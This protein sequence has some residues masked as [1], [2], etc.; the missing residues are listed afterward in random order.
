MITD[1]II[2]LRAPEPSDV[3]TLYIWENDRTLWPD[4]RTRAPL[5]RHQLW[6][7]IDSYSADPLAEGQARFLIV[8]DKSGESVGAVDLFDID[9]VN[10][11]AAV[12][13]F[14]APQHRCWGI[15]LR[16][17]KLIAGYCRMELGL[18]QLWAVTAASNTA[19][20]KLFEAAGFAVAGR[21]RSWVRV[22]QASY[23]DAYIMQLLLP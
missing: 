10:R 17:V 1:S 13:I 11:R 20:R 14:V 18:H 19:S 16:A 6:Q 9:T 3:D 2:S 4:G 12:G 23:S 15:A 21:L 8:D 7:Y 22:S 5:S